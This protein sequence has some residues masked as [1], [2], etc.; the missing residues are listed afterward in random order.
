MKKNSI[1]DILLA[2]VCICSGLICFTATCD[3]ATKKWDAA[4]Q[5]TE[6]GSLITVSRSASVGSGFF[7]GLSIDGKRVKTL[8]K[9]SVYRGTLS[10]GKHVISVMPDPNTSGQRENKMEVLAE[11]DRSYSF[12]ATRGKSGE[13]VLVKNP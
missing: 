6:A 12:T 4:A 9:G 10:P 1:S 5:S 2:L 8:M 3:G 13:I 11:K 7:L